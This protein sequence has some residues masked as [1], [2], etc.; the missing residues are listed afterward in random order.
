MKKILWAVAILSLLA[1]AANV[2][3][4]T[5]EH[6][7]KEADK[8]ESELK[9]SNLPIEVSNDGKKAEA[10]KK[11]K[12]E[13]A[14]SDEAPAQANEKPKP[15][16]SQSEMATRQLKLGITYREAKN[17]AESFNCLNKAY[18]HFK[19]A[20]NRYWV[21]ACY[22]NFGYLY[23]DLD[24]L[25]LAY[26]FL[27]EARNIYAKLMKGNKGSAA[28][29][30]DILGIP[31]NDRVPEP[32]AKQKYAK[33]EKKNAAKHHPE[34]E[35]MQSSNSEIHNAINQ[36]GQNDTEL[37]SMIRNANARLDAI[38]GDI[39]EIKETLEKMMRKMERK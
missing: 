26:A 31:E 2:S 3:R 22:E 21:A 17:Y 7:K 19:K 11:I 27:R 28:A 9:K 24:S 37:H 23:R 25:E 8:A 15:R 29:V 35:K 16:T 33:K 1:F 30:A 10:S 13:K 4:A 38:D 34:P 12:N 6:A 20:G 32:K 39:R 36:L 5:D 18:K 14:K